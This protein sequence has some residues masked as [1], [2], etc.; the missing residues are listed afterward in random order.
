MVE[1]FIL[2]RWMVGLLLG[3]VL[4]V[5]YFDVDDVGIKGRGSTSLPIAFMYS[6]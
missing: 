3:L 4:R 1:R 5:F 6:S 2:M